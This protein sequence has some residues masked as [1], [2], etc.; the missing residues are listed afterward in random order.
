MSEM[1][2]AWEAYVERFAD[3]ETGE[4]GPLPLTHGAAF[5]E[6]WNAAKADD[7]GLTLIT[8]AEAGRRLRLSPRTIRTA[9]YE[10]RLRGM[11]IDGM[12]DILIYATSVAWY[13]DNR[14]GK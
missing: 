14:L 12:R 1:R 5:E 11:R 6:G 3:A 8:T 9:Y 4:P 10:G 2:A 7:I 13:R